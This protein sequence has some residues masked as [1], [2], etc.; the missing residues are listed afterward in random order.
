MNRQ[1]R[2]KLE[3]GDAVSGVEW[4]L[5]SERPIDKIKRLQAQA[6]H[7]P[8]G[9]P[10]FSFECPNC[11]LLADPITLGIELCC[12]YCQTVLGLDGE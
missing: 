6:T 10:A 11:R 2:C 12:Q 4:I 9:T 8:I 1:L 3:V 5:T 7:D